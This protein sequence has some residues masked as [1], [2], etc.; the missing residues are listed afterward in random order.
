MYFGVYKFKSELDADDSVHYENGDSNYYG[1]IVNSKTVDPIV[2][3]GRD[4]GNIARYINHSHE[5]NCVLQPWVWK[6]RK[7]IAV[8]SSTTI[9]SYSEITV[10]YEKH[11]TEFFV[12][13]Q[14]AKQKKHKQ[15]KLRSRMKQKKAMRY[16]IVT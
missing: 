3:D 4:R 8:L 13:V 2:I 10:Q 16:R 11:T 9:Y 15:K 1:V 7:G 12:N 6:G 14:N 5:P